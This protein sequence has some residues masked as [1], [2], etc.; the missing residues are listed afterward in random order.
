MQVEFAPKD[1]VK[2]IHEN[3]PKKNAVENKLV[4]L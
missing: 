3:T 1:H 2:Q 4:N